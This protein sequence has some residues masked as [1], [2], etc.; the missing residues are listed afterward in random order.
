MTTTHHCIR[1]QPWLLTSPQREGDEA[2]SP[3]C[4]DTPEVPGGTSDFRLMCHPVA[5][6]RVVNHWA[7]DTVQGFVGPNIPSQGYLGAW[8]QGDYPREGLAERWGGQ[9][10]RQMNVL[11][12]SNLTSLTGKKKDL[13]LV[14][15]I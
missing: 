3:D 7:P 10:L 4:A 11:D 6:V 8:G 1:L 2:R 13:H 5:V 9:S 14:L 15:F 12:D